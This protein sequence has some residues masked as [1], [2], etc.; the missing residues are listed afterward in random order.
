MRIN[1]EHRLGVS[2]A[3]FAVEMFTTKSATQV[4]PNPNAAP[5]HPLGLHLTLLVVIHRIVLPDRSETRQEVCWQASS[6]CEVPSLVKDKSVRKKGLAENPGKGKFIFYIAHIND[7]FRKGLRLKEKPPHILV[8]CV[9]RIV[10][11]KSACRP[12]L[13]LWWTPSHTES[14]MFLEFTMNKVA[15]LRAQSSKITPRCVLWGPGIWGPRIH[16]SGL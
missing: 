12:I 16:T 1:T 2:V 8:Q 3:R 5:I 11:D 15:W 14:T 9:A 7:P 13:I 6:S 4:L 10:L